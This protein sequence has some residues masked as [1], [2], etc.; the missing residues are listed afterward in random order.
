MDDETFRFEPEQ[1]V[2]VRVLDPD[3][4]VVWEGFGRIEL[5]MATQL[6]EEAG[7]GGD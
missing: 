3:G 4:N 7:D 2:S 5:E 6:G 1:Q